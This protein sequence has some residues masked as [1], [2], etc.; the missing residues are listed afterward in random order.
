MGLR[1]HHRIS[2]L[3][4]V[5]IN[6]GL[7][8]ASLNLGVPGANITVGPHELAGTLGIPGTG[9]SW[10][11]TIGA[12]HRNTH[13]S[14]PLPL[15][16][17]AGKPFRPIA[18]AGIE[19]LTSANLAPLHDL[20]LATRAERAEATRHLDSCE[21]KLRRMQQ[22]AEQLRDREAKAREML[23]RLRTS[24][25][26]RLRGAKIERTERLVESEAA[27]AAT[28]ADM[29]RR[30]GDLV[31]VARERRDST[32]LNLTVELSAS[33]QRAWENLEAAFD[34]L[35]RSAAIWDITA[36]RAKRAGEER[37]TATEIV[38]RKRVKLARGE[39]DVLESRH[40]ALQWQNA[41]GGDIFL[42]PGFILIFRNETDFALIDFSEIELHV[43]MVK[44]TESEQVP[45]DA[46]L[47]GRTWALAN[48][49]GTRDRRYAN[50]RELPVLAY[51][52]FLWQSQSGLNEAFQFSNWD[53]ASAFG[54]AFLEFGAETCGKVLV[55]IHM[56]NN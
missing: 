4:G 41:N 53:T 25:F 33:A 35:C 23:R 17:S 34:A 56:N 6:L 38:E 50:N 39:V 24:W 12:P 43:S 2:L 22:D 31:E 51:A 18:S 11:K 15:S 3:P 45:A 32:W 49:D 14:V 16:P 46:L 28:G 1:F 40:S 42:L 7:N 8:G 10:R 44:F 47:I 20:V 30:A 37:S 52:Q 5:H 48:R 54:L 9:L 55:H 13:P 27:A 36:S 21:R 19:T 29:L 26:R